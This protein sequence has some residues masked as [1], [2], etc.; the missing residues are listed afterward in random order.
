MCLSEEMD[1]IF[2]KNETYPAPL[3]G[4]KIEYMIEFHLDIHQIS[5]PKYYDL[6][7]NYHHL[8]KSKLN[9]NLLIFDTIIDNAL[10]FTTI[11]FCIMPLCYGSNLSVFQHF[12]GKESAISFMLCNST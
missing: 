9:S 10:V 11:H 1:L 4:S 3:I 12:R 6:I 7:M 8:S 2:Q 5:L